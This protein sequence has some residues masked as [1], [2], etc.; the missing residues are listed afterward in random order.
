MFSNFISFNLNLFH[1]CSVF[2]RLVFLN[3]RF[4][5][6]IKVLILEFIHSGSFG[7]IVTFLFGIVSFAAVNICF[8]M[9]SEI[10]FISL[11]VNNAPQLASFCFCL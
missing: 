6:L 2:V 4:R 9:L 11:E 10:S 1:A 5:C 8:I 3:N 7:L